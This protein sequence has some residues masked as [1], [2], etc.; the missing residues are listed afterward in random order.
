MWKSGMFMNMEM[1]PVTRLRIGPTAVPAVSE[2]SFGRAPD[3]K[4][5]TAVEP[6]SLLSPVSRPGTG[7]SRD[8]ILP[9]FTLVSAASLPSRSPNRDW[10]RFQKLA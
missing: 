9:K 5:R 3:R 10:A 7:S 2:M 6:M 1:P 8:T 4:D